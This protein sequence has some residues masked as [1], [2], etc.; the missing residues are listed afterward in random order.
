MD[1]LYEVCTGSVISRKG[2][3]LI[4]LPMFVRRLRSEVITGAI[5]HLARLEQFP[6]VLAIRSGELDVDGLSRPHECLFGIVI[7]TVESE[8]GTGGFLFLPGEAGNGK[9][10]PGLAVFRHLSFSP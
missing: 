5:L 6:V 4:R 1:G 7:D 10:G 2:F 8:V 9:P 3:R